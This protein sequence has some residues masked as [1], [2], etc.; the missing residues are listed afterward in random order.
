M[1]VKK[2]LEFNNIIS[3]ILKNDEV[4]SLRH[5]K[6]HGISRLDHS[7][8]VAKLAFNLCR[9][10]NL[11]NIEEVT[12]AALLHDFYHTGDDSSFKGHPLSARNNAK[13]VFNINLLQEDIIYNHMFPAT[14]RLPKYKETWLVSL[15]D[16]LIAIKECTRYKIPL[17]AGTTFLFI[18]NFLILPR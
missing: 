1:K 8:S 6:H 15:S 7:L 2:Q 16:K 14:L 9:I 10:F 13:R 3:D 17:E 11:K 18:F 12:R 4:I 5:E